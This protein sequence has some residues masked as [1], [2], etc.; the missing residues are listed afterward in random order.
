MPPDAAIAEQNATQVRRHDFDIT[1]T[2]RTPVLCAGL[3]KK[4]W[5]LDFAFIRNQDGAPIIPRDHVK[6][7]V[8]QALETLCRH[9]GLVD[10]D[11]ITRWLGKASE[12]KG[13]PEKGRVIFDDLVLR[14]APPAPEAPYARIRIDEDKGTVEKGMLAFIE[15][16]APPGEELA[17]SGRITALL[18]EDD[19][20]RFGKALEKALKLIPAIGA[21]KSVGFGEVVST[22]VQSSSPETTGQAALSLPNAESVTFE[23][24]FDRPLIIDSRK[25]ADNLVVGSE[26]I[27]GGA[28]KGALAWL[29]GVQGR[30]T[31][32]SDALS[33]IV[34]SHAFPLDDENKEELA[35]PIPLCMASFK[36]KDKYIFKCDLGGG[37]KPLVL[38][39][40]APFYPPDWKADAFE[41]AK[42]QLGYPTKAVL[43]REQRTRVAIDYEKG[44]AEESQLFTE[45]AISERIDGKKKRR[46]RFTIARNGAD[47]TEFQQLLEYL[48]GGLFNLGRTNATMT[49]EEIREADAP[50]LEPFDGEDSIY[51]VMLL[52]PAV[53]L[54]ALALLDE[55]GEWA[56]SAKEAYQDY[57]KHV[58]PDAELVDF[59]ASQR[60]AG[61]YLGL[62][63][64][65]YGNDIYYPFML[66]EPGSVFLL[67]LPN[68]GKEKL[69]NFL[70]HNLP[71]APLNGQ[72]PTWKESPFVPKNGYGRIRCFT[73]SW[74][75][76]GRRHA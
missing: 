30:I 43:R 2:V 15:Q 12:K 52:T 66:T 1:I 5:G 67:R 59:M 8:R 55:Q 76:G 21:M 35:H 32:F 9:T 71:H 10:A 48:C 57:W 54:D 72:E 63:F 44:A 68:G 14:D 36:H 61:G 27:P 26:V 40:Q 51:A 65:P 39:G 42:T 64:R 18:E 69:E 22:Q 70:R 16:I 75:E 62:R 6:G 53:I 20:K 56:K 17:F 11:D 24:T 74:I 28:I 60:W 34:I 13:E 33:Q 50:G 45:V 31:E 46:W 73:R 38:N 25:E 47:E 49:V 19:A 23:V 3:D 58:L 37:D 41:A 7:H 29:L 4:A